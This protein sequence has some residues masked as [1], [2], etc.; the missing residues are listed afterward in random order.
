M[1]GD[2]DNSQLNKPVFAPFPTGRS[3]CSTVL[4]ILLQGFGAFIAEC[5]TNTTVVITMP[6][7]PRV[8]TLNLVT[9]FSLNLILGEFLSKLFTYNSVFIKSGQT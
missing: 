8:T 3:L 2:D 6:A 5:S 1:T 9:G 4:P 7:L